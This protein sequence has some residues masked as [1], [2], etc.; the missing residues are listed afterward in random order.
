MKKLLL[1]LLLLP[2]IGFSQSYCHLLNVVEVTT[3]TNNL[4]NIA[5][6]DEGLGN[7]YPYIAYS[8]N[9]IGDT[10]HV[11]NLDLFGNVG[12]DTTWYSYSIISSPIYPLSIYYVY[13][14]NS[15]TC[16]LNYHPS[17]DSVSVFFNYIDSLTSP[18]Q[19]HINIETLNFG[20]SNFGYGGFVLL[21]EIGDTVASENINNAGNVYGLMQ[22]YTENRFLDLSQIISIPFNGTLHLISGFFAGN[23]ITSCVFPFNIT[24]E[25]TSIKEY[26]TNKKLLKVT[27]LLGRETKKTNQPLLYIYNDGTVEKK[28]IIE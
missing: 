27:D 1:I 24:N 26:S 22:N 17:C 5:I 11:G 15:D 2:I 25:T 20:N 21:D 28:V 9:S 4:I 8:I 18:H 7:S 6:S 16:I 14:I 10:T 12:F 19:I 3:D 23:S 13:G